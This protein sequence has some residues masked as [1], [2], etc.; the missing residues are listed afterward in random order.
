MMSKFLK[1]PVFNC[2]QQELNWA[3]S[4]LSL[5]LLKKPDIM[6]ISKKKPK[7]NICMSGGVQK[8]KQFIDSLAIRY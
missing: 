6:L 7:I 3:F 2:A 1:H 5:V 8:Q 4:S